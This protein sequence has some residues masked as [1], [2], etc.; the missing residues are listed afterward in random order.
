[1][2]KAK[3]K[4]T[5]QGQCQI[6][7]RLQKLP[8][9]ALSQ[10]GY[11]VEFGFFNGV[12]PGSKQ[13]PYELSCNL[14]KEIL[15]SVNSYVERLYE[16][17]ACLSKPALTLDCFNYVW[18]TG[19]DGMRGY[20]DWRKG[21]LTIEKKCNDYGYSWEEVT[22]RFYECSIE[23]RNSENLSLLELATK[24]NSE[25]VTKF[26]IPL[27]KQT[28]GEIKRLERKINNWELRE[29]KPI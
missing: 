17:K 14:I 1:M 15:P 7:D 19:S 6:C 2:P 28:E 8:N 3:T 24:L 10:H 9:N 27:I 18:I 20:Y 12:C 23:V 29:L 5:H 22:F 21:A 4:A 16:K 11:K 25:Y 13:E 26:L